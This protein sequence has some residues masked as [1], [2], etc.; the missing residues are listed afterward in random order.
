MSDL[1]KPGITVSYESATPEHYPSVYAHA[2]KVEVVSAIGYPDHIFVFQRSKPDSNGD[3]VDE[4]IQIAAPLE[5]EEVPEDAPDLQNGMPYYRAKSVT[6]YFR[7]IEDLELAKAK[8]DEDIGMLKRT[9]DVLEHGFD[10]QE[11]RH[12]D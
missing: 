6:L 3:C 8:I 9:Y 2:L 5:I 12:Y 4:F 1:P 11:I 10:R 7:T